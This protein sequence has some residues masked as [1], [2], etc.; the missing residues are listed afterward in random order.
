MHGLLED[1]LL[2]R[3]GTHHE[4]HPKS[5]CKMPRLFSEAAT[6]ADAVLEVARFSEAF[7]VSDELLLVVVTTAGVVVRRSGRGRARGAAGIEAATAAAKARVSSEGCEASGVA[8]GVFKLVD[9]TGAG[10]IWVCICGCC[11]CCDCCCC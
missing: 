2:A 1:L 9:A 11:D 7:R 6:A 3:R 10:V 8:V 5:R 4:L